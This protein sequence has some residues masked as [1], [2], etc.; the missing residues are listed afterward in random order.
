MKRFV[1]DLVSSTAAH[2]RAFGRDESGSILQMTG[3]SII[4]LMLAAGVAIDTSRINFTH[5]KLAAGLDA[6]ALAAA[7]MVNKSQTEMEAEAKRYL[8]ANF[9]NGDTI[10]IQ[11]F[12]LTDLGQEILFEA[13]AR[14]PMTMMKIGGIDYQDIKLASTVVKDGSSVE[15]SLV[16][17]NTNSMNPYM[18]DLKTAASDFLDTVVVPAS[19]PY[20][21][22]V[23][24]VPYNRGVNMG[25][26]AASARG[27][28]NS[29]TSTTPGSTN[30]TFTSPTGASSSPATAGPVTLAITNCVSERTGAQAYTDAAVAT[31]RVGRVYANSGNPC[32]NAELK[33][34]SDD[35]TALKA[36]ITTMTAGS[37]TAGQVG[38]AWGWY[39]LSPDFGLWG[40]TSKPAAYGTEKLRKIMVLMT[41]G[42]YNSAYCKGVI[43]SNG[44][45]TTYNVGSGSV[46]DMIDCMPENDSNQ[47]GAPPDSAKPAGMSSSTWTTVK[48]NTAKNK[49]VYTQ[50]KKLCAAMKA[51]GIEIFTIEFQLDSNYADRVDLV[52]SCATDAAHR[53]TASDGASL[54]AAF[55]K[56]AASIGDPRVSK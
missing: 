19:P 45:S 5:Q 42:E 9:L 17:D 35:K 16:L 44:G 48:G 32:L 53:V 12:K 14:V 36:A 40:T 22:K 56:I 46:K 50:S 34:L 27:P 55:K 49:S 11:S 2:M 8:D 15:V 37:S 24:L 4:P 51:K 18:A 30:F 10:T 6:G 21:S 1:K 52:S 25:A 29:G 3:L 47:T 7:T 23:A 31:F 41:D 38:I 28:I 33:P 26:L 54:K 43:S 13:T 39:T 20:Y